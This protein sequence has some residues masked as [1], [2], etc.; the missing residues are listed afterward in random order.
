MIFFVRPD[1][2]R[3]TA[4]RF[5][6]KNGMIQNP[7]RNAPRD[8]FRIKTECSLI[9]PPSRHA[10]LNA[11]SKE[12]KCQDQEARKA[13]KNTM[14]FISSSTDTT[15][16]QRAISKYCA[17]SQRRCKTSGRHASAQMLMVV[18]TTPCIKHTFIRACTAWDPIGVRTL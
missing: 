5:Q 2:R 13:F 6:D 1:V 9:S 14:A 3:M 4:G 8:D 15:P 18:R 17:S 11:T 12:W 16:L 7:M 10:R